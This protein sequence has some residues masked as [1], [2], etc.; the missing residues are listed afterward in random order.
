MDPK[1][2]LQIMEGR[3]WHLQ[4][5]GYGADGPDIESW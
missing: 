1:I 2:I 3:A 5:I 4:R